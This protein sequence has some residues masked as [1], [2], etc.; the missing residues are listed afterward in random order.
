MGT[1]VGAQTRTNFPDPIL[2]ATVHSGP[3]ESRGR[4]G[5][6][7]GPRK[8]GWSKGTG[9]VTEGVRESTGPTGQGSTRGGDPEEYF[10]Y[11]NLAE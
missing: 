8:G 3:G 4:P 11:I 5:P 1:S 6:H 2:Q 9:T 7:H 10:P